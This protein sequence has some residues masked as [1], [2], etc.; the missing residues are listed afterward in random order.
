[1]ELRENRRVR[2]SVIYNHRMVTSSNLYFIRSDVFIRKMEFHLSQT[3]DW[4]FPVNEF[5]NEFNQRRDRVICFKPLATEQICLKQNLSYPL[6]KE[7]SR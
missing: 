6:T 1:V 4:H 2:T 7:I 5:G 3:H